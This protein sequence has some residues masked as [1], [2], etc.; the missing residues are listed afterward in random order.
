MIH[1]EIRVDN[2]NYKRINKT[3]ARNLFESGVQ[4][5]IAPNN[6]RILHKFD[7]KGCDGFDKF[8][9][10]YIYYNCCTELGKYPAFYIKE[11]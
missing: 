11:F 4:L 2:I 7:K 10:E 3:K 1:K 5:Y 9:N 6:G 8:V